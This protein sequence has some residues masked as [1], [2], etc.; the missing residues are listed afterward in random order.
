MSIPATLFVPALQA[1]NGKSP[2]TPDFPL[3]TP[4]PAAPTA[5]AADIQAFRN[6]MKQALSPQYQF[7]LPPRATGTAAA[8]MQP[9]SFFERAVSSLGK[10]AERRSELEAAMN[11]AVAAGDTGQTPLEMHRAAHKLSEYTT[12]TMLATKVIAKS[13]QTMNE[14]LKAQ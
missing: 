11:R 6:E 9:P 14:L 7:Y 8:G 3:L 1:E 10:T 4:A 5:A 2:A 12:E 13:T